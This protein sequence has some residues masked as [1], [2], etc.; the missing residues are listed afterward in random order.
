[1]N[2]PS[3]NPSDRAPASRPIPPY[4]SGAAGGLECAVTEFVGWVCA[5]DPLGRK[6]RWVFSNGMLWVQA[7]G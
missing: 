1:M 2:S 5:L 4:P 7:E 6:Q 3:P